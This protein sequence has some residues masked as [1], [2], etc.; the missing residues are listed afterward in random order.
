VHATG[1]SRRRDATRRRKRDATNERR[2]CGLRRVRARIG[3][4]IAATLHCAAMRV[5]SRVFV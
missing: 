4:A 5:A 1:N 2:A 3:N